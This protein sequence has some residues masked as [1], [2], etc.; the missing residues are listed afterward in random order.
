[1]DA[2]EDTTTKTV[3]V[4]KALNEELM[5]ALF[6]VM[7][8]DEVDAH[9]DVTSEQEIRKAC[10]NYNKYSREANLFHEGS[11]DSFELADSY[12]LPISCFIGERFVKKGT[13]LATV[14]A[15]DDTLWE[16]IKSGELCSLSIGAIA[17][18]ENLE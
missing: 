8:P 7:V 13:W 9:G 17:R 11:T 5:Q 2:T 16:L 1:M 14:Q 10:F 3:P 18:V 4:I 12:I 15:K 6:V